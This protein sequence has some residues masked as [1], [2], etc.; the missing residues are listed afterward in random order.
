MTAPKR[1]RLAVCC[2][3]IGSVR[4]GNFGWW[5]QS[6][7]PTPESEAGDRLEILATWVAGQINLGCKVALG[8]ECPL[9]VPLPV[10]AE[11]LGRARAGE[12]NRPWS[13]GAGSG[14]LA[15]GLAQ[16]PWILGQIRTSTS[17]PIPAWL[18]WDQFVRS[19]TGLFLW[20]AFV[21]GSSKGTSHTDDARKA[22]AAFQNS[23][24][25]PFQANAVTCA[26]GTVSLVGHAIVSTDWMDDLPLLS[27]PCLVI[28]V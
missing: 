13:A 23:L 22:V 16:V 3:D 28:R 9:F 1:D 25:S 26:E 24:P 8:F 18:D 10:N 6:E 5:A 19:E 12:G 17:Q 2:A 14:A 21:S 11:D 27:Q 15:T 4:Q 20:E 7:G